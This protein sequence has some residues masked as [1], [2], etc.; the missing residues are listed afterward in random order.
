VKAGGAEKAL[1]AR[2]ARAKV[3][4]KASGRP[5][6]APPRRVKAGGAEKA[7]PARLARAKVEDRANGRRAQAN[8][9]RATAR[10]AE[11]EPALALLAPAALAGLA[12]AEAVVVEPE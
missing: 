7:L 8:A 3:E 1:L 4:D 9:P 6:L 5:A 2:V 12:L 10:G 11:R